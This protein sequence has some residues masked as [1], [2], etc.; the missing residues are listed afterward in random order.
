MDNRQLKL[1]KKV[2]FKVKILQS[3]TM[4]VA[5]MQSWKKLMKQCLNR[6]RVFDIF[7]LCNF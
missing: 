1:S 3:M 6:K 5:T 7:F 4:T 2:R